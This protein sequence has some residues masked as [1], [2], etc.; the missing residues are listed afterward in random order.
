MIRS[1]KTVFFLAVLFIIAYFAKNML[2]KAAVIN[3]MRAATGLQMD[4]RVLDVNFRE[5]KVDIRDL[6]VYNPVNF[7]DG[8]MFEVP[9]VYARFDLADLVRKK[10]TIYEGRL[11]LKELHLE[12]SAKGELNLVYLKVN[13]NAP[14]PP[15]GTPRRWPWK[16]ARLSLRVDKV[17]YRDHVQG[18]GAP[19]QEF[20]VNVDEELSNITEPR[21]LVRLVIVRALANTP[22]EALMTLSPQAV[23]STLKGGVKSAEGITTG[24]V[25]TTGKIIKR[26]AEELKNLIL[27]EP[28]K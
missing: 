18:S 2:I 23:K 15:P 5:S 10:L 1:I 4:I 9:H 12:R 13:R 27:G 7:E 3:A 11:Y 6:K 28:A 17:T 24:A 16:I 14:P 26:S 8:V 25:K 19:L 21:E 20:N 22:L